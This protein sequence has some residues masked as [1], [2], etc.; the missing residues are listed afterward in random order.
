MEDNVIFYESIG[1]PT[2]INNN[3]LG[4]QNP[5]RYTL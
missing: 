2:G 5:G 3:V 4:L 1:N